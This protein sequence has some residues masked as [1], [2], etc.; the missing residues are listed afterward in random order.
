MPTSCSDCRQSFEATPADLAFYA[1]IGVPSPQCCSQ[2]R[3]MRR[4]CERNTRSLYWRK[5]DATGKRILSQHHPD[6]PFPVYEPDAWWSDSWDGLSYGVKVDLGKPFFPQFLALKNRVPHQS[7]FVIQGTMENSEYTNCAGYSKNL[8]LCF[9]ADYDEDCAYSNRIYHCTDVLDCSNCYT[10]ELCYECIDCTDCQRLHFSQDC[11]NCSESAFLQNC[12]GCR[13]CIGCIN[14]RQ[15]RFMIGN[16]QM[17]EEDFRK[18]SAALRLN[19]TKGIEEYKK[20]AGA[21]FVTQPQRFVQAERNE[22]CT[23]DHLYDSKNSTECFDCRDLEDCR[24]CAKVSMGVKSSM[25]YN[26][27]GDKAER[28]YQCSACGNNAFNLKFCST[29]T[30]NNSDLEY[31]DGCTGCSNCFGCV[32]LK[33]KKYCILNT[34]YSKEEFEKMRGDLV[35]QME[36]N[37]EWGEYFPKNVCP[38][39]YNETIAMEYYPINKEEALKRG[40]RWREQKDDLPEVAK[41]LPAEKLPQSIAEIPDDVLNWAITSEQSKR[42]YRITKQELTFYRSRNLPLPHLHPDERNAQR[43]AMRPPRRLWERK[44]SGCSKEMESTFS[45]ERTERVLCASCYLAAVYA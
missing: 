30:T 17:T 32:G 25:D 31:C 8:Y 45:S 39:A 42:P 6:Q 12:A 43:F 9:E 7:R 44:C 35:S 22:G 29:C 14:Q 41:I 33:K 3:A 19:T 4:F 20:I 16:A 27:W 1:D 13:D 23:G 38:Y 21:F 24:F 10:C 15:K 34:Q 2:C 26:S 40:Y 37:S 36:K 11:Q 28:M 5:C 18:Q